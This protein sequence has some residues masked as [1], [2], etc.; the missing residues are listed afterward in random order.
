MDGQ[1]E[2]VIPIEIT[3]NDVRD[4]VIVAI[5]KAYPVAKVY[6]EQLPQ[7][8]KEPCFFVLMLEGSQDK[9]LDRRY[10]RFH[11]F[12]IHYFASS[13]S[14]RYEVAE[15]L[16]DI[17]GLIEMQGKPIRGSKMRHTIVDDVLHFFVDYNFHVVRPKP[18]VPTMQK[19]KIEGGLKDG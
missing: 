16:T 6:G 2:E 12:D 1:L 4:A 13:N 5:K 7:G 18:V 19:V 3:I 8:F 14:E 17:L 15:K 11:P 10:K 9:E